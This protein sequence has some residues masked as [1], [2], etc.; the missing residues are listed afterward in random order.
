MSV[1]LVLGIDP[2]TRKLGWGLIARRGQ[3]LEHVAHGV[4][5]LD[6]QAPLGER[7]C[8][9]DRGLSEII[10]R[11]RPAVGSVESLFFHKD[12]Q[13]AAKLGHARGVR[14]RFP[15][16]DCEILV[17]VAHLQTADDRCLLFVAQLLER[18]VVEG[19]VL[20]ADRD[21]SVVR[22]LDDAAPEDVRHV[23]QVGF[24]ARA[25]TG[26][27]G[28]WVEQSFCPTCGSL[29]FMTGEGL[30]G[31]VSV[32]VGC[33]TDPDF[34]RPATLFRARRKHHWFDPGPGTRISD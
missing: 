22:G 14:G 25:R 26:D 23:E 7:L 34:A 20:L 15:E 1:P 10:G 3:R 8:A 13:A 6:A 29:L 27:A 4:L 32:S 28:R 11:H 5:T 19:G 18:L 17:A 24:P 30:P 9:I 21:A 2:G 12:P 16:H 31:A 33:F